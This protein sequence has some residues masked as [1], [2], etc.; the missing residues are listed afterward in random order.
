MVLVCFDIYIVK[1][2]ADKYDLTVLYASPD[3]DK[4]MTN[5]TIVFYEGGRAKQR[6][7]RQDASNKQVQTGDDVME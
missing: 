1:K 7:F 6:V 4:C 3:D 2:I 5:C